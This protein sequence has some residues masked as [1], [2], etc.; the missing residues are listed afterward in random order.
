[1]IGASVFF[2]KMGNMLK[3]SIII[4][5]WNV[6]DLLRDCLQSVFASRCGQALEVVVVDN[7]SH[8]GST[9]MV[10]A[11]FPQVILI[12][13][14]KNLGF[15]RGNNLGMT[16]ATG[17]FIFF[18]NPDTTLAEDTLMYLAAY[19][20]EH[21]GVGVVGPQLRYPDGTVQSSR[22]RFP[23][24][25]SVFLESTLLEQ[26]LPNN[27]TAQQYRFAD[28]PDTAPMPVDWL[29]GA[30]LF[31][32][33]EVWTQVGPFDDTL[34]MYF[35]ETDWCRRCVESGWQIHYVPEA[36]VIHYE[37]QSSQQVVADRTMRFNRSKIRYTEKWLGS[38]WA[39][40]VQV[41]LLTTFGYQWLEETIK[42]LL[43]H[44]RPLRRARMAVYQQVLK[45]RL[46]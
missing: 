10:S 5:N 17:D 24:V 36:Q 12:A 41:F 29:M 7:A 13:S 35:E 39:K 8:D 33:K 31:V 25:G 43:G 46:R 3:I 20:E 21:P 18:L 32:R 4:V 23:T 37:G 34:F 15:A 30:A 38:G 22:R 11:E 45:S 26:W 6:K 19:L 28:Q 40:G 9:T 1:M 42:W 27:H 14:D 16:H 44:K 2:V